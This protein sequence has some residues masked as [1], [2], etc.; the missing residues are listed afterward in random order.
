MNNTEKFW[1]QISSRETQT[2]LLEVENNSSNED[3]IISDLPM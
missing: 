3:N 1:T 2:I